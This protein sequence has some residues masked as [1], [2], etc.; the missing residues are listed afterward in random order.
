MTSTTTGS[1]VL[2][3][4]GT[5]SF[6]QTMV[7]HLLARG[8]DEVRV[9]SRDEAK[10]DAMRRL[11]GDRRVR[12]YMGD[13]RDHESVLHA[14]R[15]VHHIFHAAALKQVPSC[16][17]FPLEAVRTNVHGTANVV[18]AAHRNG[19]ESVVVLST[20]KAVRPVNA[21]GMSKALMEKVVQAHARNNPDSATV[22]SCVRY[23]N[24]MYSRGSVI[25]MFI[26]QIKAGRPPTV[27]DPTMTRFL[28]S[29]TDSV[30]LVEHAFQ[31]ARPGDV[32]IRKAVACTIGDLAEA[33]C[34]LFDVPAKLDVIGI[35]H[36]EKRHET[37]AS[38]ED[39][40]RAED[41]GEF[42][43]VPLDARDLNY[44]LY[45]SE[46]DLGGAS[47]ADFDSANALRL[48]VSEIVELL[49]TLPEV[50]VEL[51]LSDAVPAC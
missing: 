47:A 22:V 23:G 1:C 3:T 15:G 35:R 10:Q 45:I 26:E 5:G 49:L 31:H 18:D 2:I 32:F 37:L 30:A 44:A 40:A 14:S 25:P 43:R 8:V 12:Y 7:R 28:M 50:R 4:G 9:L 41:F 24:V 20:D 11:I 16:E 46:G 17:F 36:G 21:M 38:R 13:V 27:T 42:F 33:V 6:G 29:L 34:Q 19:V 48:S 51:D 39:L